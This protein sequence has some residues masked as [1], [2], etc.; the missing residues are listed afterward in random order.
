MNNDHY[1]T[2]WS[3]NWRKFWHFIVYYWATTLALYRSLNVK[4]HKI[5]TVARINYNLV[6]C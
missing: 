3:I 4:W 2:D 6:W 5:I 1:V